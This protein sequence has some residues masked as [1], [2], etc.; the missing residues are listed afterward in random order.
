MVG[1][2]RSIRAIRFIVV[3]ALLAL[4]S[5][6]V[7]TQSPPP[8]YYGITAI[9]P[10]ETTASVARDIA[11]YGQLMVGTARA[12]N[13]HLHAFAQGAYVGLRDLG[14]LGGEM[15]S[16][17]AVSGPVVVGESQI[18]SGETRAFVADL[19]Q[20]TVTNLGTLGGSW[21][22]AYDVGSVV[23][24]GSS[25]AGDARRRAFQYLN[26]VMSPIP[27]DW[28]GDSLANGVNGSGEIVGTACTSGNAACR[29]FLFR[30]GAVTD[31]GP[32]N[33]ISVANDINEAGQIVGA[34]ERAGSSV[35]HAFLYADGV[36]TDLSTLGGANSEALAI[37]ERGDVVG[38]SQT[39]AGEQRAFL[40]RDGVMIDLNTLLPPDSGWVLTTANS[41][42][43]GG[44]IVGGAF[45]GTRAYLLTPPT[46]LVT[47]IGGVRS[48]NDSNLPRGVEVGKT[49]G[50]TTSV[51]NAAPE[52]I[53]VYNATLTHT[54]TG[55]AQFVAA[56]GYDHDSCDVSPTV[57]T[58]RIHGVDSPGLGREFW[59]SARTTGPGPITHRAVVTSSVPDPN[60]NND[61]ISEDNRAIA[62]ATFVLSP[63][64]VAGGK[65]SAA[66]FSLTDM[67]P[68]G[69]AILRL[70]SSNPAVVPVP[71]TF[72]IPSWTQT[73]ALNI[74]PKV[75][76]SATTAEI[77]ATYGLV[78]I[79][80]TL[81]VLPP[82]L[83]QLYLTPTT[84]IGGCGVSAGRILLSG[85]APSGGAVVPLTNTNTKAAVP[86]NVTVPAGATSV[87]FSVPT[88]AVTTPASGTVTARYGG[89][90]QTL[91]LTVR[92]IRVQTIGMT[93][94]PAPGGTMVSGTIT[95]ECPAAPGA[96]AVTL[97]SSAPGVAS[98]TTSSIV[99]P[100]GARTGSFTIRTAAV[101]ANTPV[102]IS[103]WAFGVRKTATLTVSP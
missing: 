31:L 62:L 72:V 86:A 67:P 41:I 19:N 50:F 59:A 21:S 7:P 42:S 92:P 20:N 49:V 9:G 66:H 71:S 77:T 53:T 43:D 102:T 96:I 98:P 78:T 22:A 76:S 34:F 27:F 52:G 74:I 91:N 33:G 68:A 75:V 93:P 1:T 81:T 94:N 69:D 8:A 4:S 10:A 29:A 70:T 58:C 17:V 3:L 47:W 23:V 44:Q 24:G 14:T 2:H 83:A 16:A 56:G 39:S 64:T 90:S 25:T 30:G 35:R 6:R 65:A 32:P 73:R 88:S 61:A 97:T 15:S 48:M 80:R 79:T 63:D 13:G 82:K 28:G 60:A 38:W 103:A 57:V 36:M 84:V 37:N 26:G 5:V 100:V 87:T 55:P 40:W 95:L 54:L 46:D 11:E 101:A 51:V 18:A 85:A 12:A 99:I 45:G 89:V